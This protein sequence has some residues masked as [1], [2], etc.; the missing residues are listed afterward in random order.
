M[1]DKNGEDETQ[2]MVDAGHEVQTSHN[3]CGSVELG[4]NCNS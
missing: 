4:L 2:S 3:E 1:N